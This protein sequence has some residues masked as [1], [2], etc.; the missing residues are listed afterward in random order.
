VVL[1]ETELEFGLPVLLCEF[2]G[3]LSPYAVY[4]A[5]S[6]KINNKNKLACLTCIRCAGA[7]QMAS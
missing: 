7:K 6:V 2:D 4:G 3:Q 1:P 5:C